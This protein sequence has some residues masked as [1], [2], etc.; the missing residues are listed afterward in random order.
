M[1]LFLKNQY[2]QGSGIYHFYPRSSRTRYTLLLQYEKKTVL[3]TV[4]NKRISKRNP[5]SFI[6]RLELSCWSRFGQFGLST[7]IQRNRNVIIHDKLKN[8][9]NEI[10]L[11]EQYTLRLKLFCRLSTLTF[12]YH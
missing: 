5:S 6:T 8:E 3:S 11:H 4:S 1:C 7:R 12:F 10:I 2:S 9:G